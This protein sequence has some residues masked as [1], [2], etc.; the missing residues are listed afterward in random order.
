M[1]TKRKSGGFSLTELMIVVA[2]IGI[3]AGIAYPSYQ[4]YTKQTRREAAKAQLTNAAALY[5]QFYLNNKT[6]NT[7][8]T[9]L[10][11]PTTTEG[12]FY[13]LAGVGTATT[14]TLTAT[15]SGSQA[16]DDC[17]TLTLTKGGNN[18]PANCW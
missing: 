2:A 3:L 13:T 16:T 15:P 10:G 1:N 14:F 12:G 7:T 4:N 9:V 11:L 17:G 5:E 8:F 18:T 6:F